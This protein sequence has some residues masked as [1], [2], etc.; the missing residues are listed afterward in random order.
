MP[1]KENFNIYIY[2]LVIHYCCFLKFDAS[3]DW[4]YRLALPPD[5]DLAMKNERQRAL[6]FGI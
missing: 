2:T 6:K 3:I 5:L 4:P 1:S